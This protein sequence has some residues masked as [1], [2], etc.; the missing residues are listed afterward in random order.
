MAKGGGG[1]SGISRKALEYSSFPPILQNSLKEHGP[2][3][4]KKRFLCGKTTLCGA[5]LNQWASGV[6]NRIT[7]S[8][9]NIYGFFIM[10]EIRN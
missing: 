2:L 8:S 1:M 6:K 3:N 7:E 5:F 9:K 4:S 10:P